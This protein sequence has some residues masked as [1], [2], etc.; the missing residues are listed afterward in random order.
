MR[1]GPHPKVSAL[2]ATEWILSGPGLY[3]VWLHN[4]FDQGFDL[5]LVINPPVEHFEAQHIEQGI[6]ADGA[7]FQSIE[8]PLEA[9]LQIGGLMA[10]AGLEHGNGLTQASAQAGQSRCLVRHRMHVRC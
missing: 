9:F 1:A 10:L 5:D 4:W 6:G 8:N 3:W 7:T 2:M